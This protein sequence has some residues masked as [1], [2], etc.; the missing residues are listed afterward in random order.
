VTD[1]LTAKGFQAKTGVSDDVLNRLQT[2]ADLLLKWQATINL[3]GSGTLPQVWSRH[4]LDSAQLALFI[5][6]GSRVVDLGS[7]AGFPGL[8]LAIIA[9]VDMHLVESDQRK[10]AF[11]R[12]VNRA[13]Q[14]RVHIHTARIE[15]MKSLEADVVTARA[16]A[17]LDTLLGYA[18]IHRLSTGKCLFLKGKR[19][20]EELTEAQKHWSMAALNHPSRTDSAGRILEL[21]DLK[22]V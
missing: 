7:G 12:E 22:R 14:A 13:T 1:F 19:W 16:L 3:V 10:C 18:D 21:S 15:D 20:K 4:M 9:G 17:N 8:V 11:L 6:V 2:Y 5:P